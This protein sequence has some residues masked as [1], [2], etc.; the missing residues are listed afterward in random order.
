MKLNLPKICYEPSASV[1]NKISCSGAEKSHT[2]TN[3]KTHFREEIN[4]QRIAFTS[5]IYSRSFLFKAQG[6]S[7]Q[8]PLWVL[9]RMEQM[10]WWSEGLAQ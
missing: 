5:L 2:R 6:N 4:F 7:I 8:K 10:V 3:E 9:E 1:T